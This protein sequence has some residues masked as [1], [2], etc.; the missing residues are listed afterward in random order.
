MPVPITAVIIV[1]NEEERIKKAMA[2]AQ[3]VADEII[4]VDD[5]SSDGTADV[6][7]AAG[8]RVVSRAL[9][10]N[11]AAQRNAG[12]VLAKN[13]WILVIDAD[14]I[15]PEASVAE[16]RRVFSGEVD[17]DAASFRIVNVLFDTPLFYSSGD[18]RT[19]RLYRRS[20]CSFGGEVHEKLSVPGSI[21]PLDG[22][23]W[24]YPARR[25]DHVFVKALQ[26]TEVEAVRFCESVASVSER[27]IRYQLTWKSLKRFWKLY[28][29][30]KGYKDGLP[31]LV[32]SV[33]NVIGPQLRWIKI[34]EQAKITGKLVK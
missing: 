14:E 26:Y 28:I 13:D 24:N 20:R 8:A 12:A 34:W 29:K 4:V 31:G 30:N 21:L 7:R 27:E 22:Q 17:A 25:M 11:F 33:C 23:I 10:G 1:R 19:V 32:W 2:S 3:A 6:A 15:L 9:N 18:C 16:L 5:G